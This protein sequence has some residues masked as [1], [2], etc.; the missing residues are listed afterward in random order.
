[1]RR[2]LLA[3]LLIIISATI[4]TAQQSETISS[5]NNQIYTNHDGNKSIATTDDGAMVF[6]IN[7][8]RFKVGSQHTKQSEE[9]IRMPNDDR[10]TNRRSGS[11]VHFGI[12]G[13]GAP[14]YNH[15]A[16]FEV[17]SSFFTGEKFT[18]YST[19][20]Q[21]YMSFDFNK[22]SHFTANLLHLNIA[23]DKRNIS[24]LT[25]GFGVTTEY[26]RMKHNTTLGYSEGKI[27]AI[28]LS[29]DI[30][31]SQLITQYLHIPVLFDINMGKNFFFSAGA[32]FN[33]LVNS[34]LKYKKP[35]T[36]IE[37]T[38]PLNPIQIDIMARIGWKRLYLF[39]NYSPMNFYKN[40]TGINANR[41]SIG[42][43]I[44]F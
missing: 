3:I 18:G 20:E 31:K 40:S 25:I 42:A 34:M 27:H 1:M 6:V 21:E 22:S 13:F 32:R 24:T 39:A 16:L 2:Q 26:Y 4:A 10:Y 15:L 17:G 23:L 37:D 9:E 44:W 30:K 33:I 36:T 8:K 28:E 35:K 14:S 12:F 38:L 19:E 43:G 5:D 11:R 7:G 41:M 29:G